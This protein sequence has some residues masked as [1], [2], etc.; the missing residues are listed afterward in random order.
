MVSGPGG[1]GKTYLLLND[2]VW[3]E[4]MVNVVFVTESNKLCSSKRLECMRE[5]QK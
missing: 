5:W 2:G 1:C 3:D 4:G